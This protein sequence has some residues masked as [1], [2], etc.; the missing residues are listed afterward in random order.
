MLASERGPESAYLGVRVDVKSSGG[1]IQGRGFRDIV[2]LPLTFLLL[3]F[4]RDTSHG[5]LLDS[6]HEM[7]RKP[8]DFVA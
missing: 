8:G 1:G 2:I 5:S 4:K 6:F 3:Q 7:S